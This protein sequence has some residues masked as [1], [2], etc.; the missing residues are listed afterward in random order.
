M[1]HTVYTIQTTIHATHTQGVGAHRIVT[2]EGT[3]LKDI[4]LAWGITIHKAQGS[5][6]DAAVL[7]ILDQHHFQV[8][9]CV[10]VHV[11]ALM[12]R[13]LPY[14]LHDSRTHTHTHPSLRLQLSRNMLCSGLTHAK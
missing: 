14:S 8:C 3:D 5:E 7:F 10:C 2:Y 13:Q 11:T 1:F 4:T 12:A 9:V 6:Y